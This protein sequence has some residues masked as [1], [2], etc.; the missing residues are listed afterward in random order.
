MFIWTARFSK[1]KAVAAVI[2][3]GLVMAILILLSGRSHTEDEARQPVLSDNTQRIAYLQ[4]LGWEVEEDPLETLQF[5]FPET[6]NASY[7]AYNELQR[8]Q[9]FD[10]TTCC[11]KQ[12]TRYTY[13]VTNYPNRPEGVQANLYICEDMAV[14]GDICCPGESGFQE[15][16]IPSEA[17]KAS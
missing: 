6:L 9:G 16:L 3:I 17:K 5:L 11:G 13:T 2:A 14:A 15:R 10:L 7:L 12:V 8:L 1:K 4:S